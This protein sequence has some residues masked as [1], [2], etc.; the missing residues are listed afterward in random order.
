MKGRIICMKMLVKSPQYLIL[1][2][3]LGQSKALLVCFQTDREPITCT[4]DRD[5][6]KG[7]FEDQTLL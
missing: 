3:H 7:V 4:L 6:Q 1:E 2:R 5:G